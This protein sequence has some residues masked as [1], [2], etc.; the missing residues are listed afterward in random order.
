M[1]ATCCKA[2][3]NP[4]KVHIKKINEIFINCKPPCE[5]IPA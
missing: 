3:I 1:G 5:Y 2:T 4:N